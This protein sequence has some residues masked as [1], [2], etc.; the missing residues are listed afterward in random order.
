MTTSPSLAVD[1]NEFSTD[2]IALQAQPPAIRARL[3]LWTLVIFAVLAVTYAFVARMDIVVTGQGRVVPSGKTAVV[4]TAASG[5]V[6]AVYVRDGQ[7]VRTGDILIAF[8]P[9]G[10][11][12]PG[13]ATG[14]TPEPATGPAGV[15][16]AQAVLDARLLESL[17]KL[18]TLQS[19][20]T[21]R[22]AERDAVAGQLTQLNASL[23]LVNRKHAM[24]QALAKTGHMAE[25][26][27]IETQ[28]EVFNLQKELSVQQ[29]RLQELD[30]GLHA[31]IQQLTQAETEFRARFPAEA[32]QIVRP[33]GHD[34]DTS[35][36]AD[37]A[38]ALKAPTT[39][40]VH[41][42]AVPNVGEPVGIGQ[43]LLVVVP[44]NA[45]LEVE[46]M[47]LN[48]DIGHLEVG[49]RAIVKIETYDYTRYGYIDGVVQWVGT[50]AIIDPKLG[51]VY[52][53]RLSLGATQT[54]NVIH[55]RRGKVAPGMSVTADVRVAE[56]RMLDYFLSPL[57][58]YKEE[59][60][61]ER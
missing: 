39:G 49:Q 37:P 4:Q 56:R 48:K 40:V 29:N 6:Q 13:V 20:V 51:P 7:R 43:N 28:L 14:A 23:P 38:Y 45:P 44:E 18:A 16:S 57:L 50:D 53:A 8:G 17:S 30:A 34:P 46:A 52:A 5:V 55:G 47:V 1:P 3:V 12:P 2:A 15:P 42:L 54:P 11:K 32:I 26:G 60:L 41:W 21:R 9:A 31:A 19:E 61:R 24:R 22:Q 33:Q 36:G 25:T 35:Q 59:S 58:R 10:A 27:V